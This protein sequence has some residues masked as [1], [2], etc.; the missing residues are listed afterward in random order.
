MKN[1]LI[2]SILLLF[3]TACTKKISFSAD[4][5]TATCVKTA[6]YEEVQCVSSIMSL[7]LPEAKADDWM[8]N[9]ANP[10]SPLSPFNPMYQDSGPSCTNKKVIVTK[11]LEY[12]VV[13][14]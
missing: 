14:K 1:L 10:I 9:P 8:M 6:Q 5:W 3:A 7:I 13:R 4:E 12:K 2:C 11:C